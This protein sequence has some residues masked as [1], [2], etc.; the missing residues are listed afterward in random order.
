MPKKSRRFDRKRVEESVNRAFGVVVNELRLQAH[1]ERL[2][3][4]ER[5]IPLLRLYTLAAEFITGQF[6]HEPVPGTTPPPPVAI[7]ERRLRAAAE[8]L[9][10]AWHA[11][12]VGEVAKFRVEAPARPRT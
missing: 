4:I 11:V 12:I 6:G 9:S 8:K 1:R 5:T 2:K 3:L 7:A 10:S